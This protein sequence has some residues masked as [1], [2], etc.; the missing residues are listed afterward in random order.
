MGEGHGSFSNPQTTSPRTV[1]ESAQVEVNSP[2]KKLLFGVCG[3]AAIRDAG[4]HSLRRWAHQRTPQPIRPLHS[5]T[6]SARTIPPAPCST[7]GLPT[8]NT[9]RITTP[10]LNAATWIWYRLATFI[11]PRS[12]VRR[13]PPVSHTC[14]KLRSTSSLRFFCSRLLRSPFTR[15]R[16]AP[17]ATGHDS[18][19]SAHVRFPRSGS[20]MYVRTHHPAHSASVS[21]LWYPLSA[22][23]SS[24]STSN[25]ARAKF[26][27]VR[28]TLSISVAVSPWSAG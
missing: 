2:L 21:D 10:K 17:V 5:H 28:S 12:H 22:T 19:L 16:L 25:P 20:G 26:T 18:G 4:G 3:S 9:D 27:W 6:T 23:T 24:T 11:R 15:R 13:P 14:A 8:P 7:R 1:T